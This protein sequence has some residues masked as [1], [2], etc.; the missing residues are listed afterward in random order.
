MRVSRFPATDDTPRSSLGYGV[1]A[2]RAALGTLYA[3]LLLGECRLAGRLGRLGTES[4]WSEEVKARKGSES[5][6][7]P[8][9]SRTPPRSVR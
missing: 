7:S 4:Q 3:L 5:K 9:P 8:Q 1:F 2:V 6:G